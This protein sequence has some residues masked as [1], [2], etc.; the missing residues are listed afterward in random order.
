MMKIIIFLFVERIYVKF[1]M[2]R[3]MGVYS[4][5]SYS[6]GRIMETVKYSVRLKAFVTIIL[7]QDVVN[8][9]AGP[10]F[11]EKSRIFLMFLPYFQDVLHFYIFKI[12]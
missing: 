1:L 5:K 3:D 12:N 9:A 10:E 8:A 11:S 7:T 4:R 6:Q 2:P